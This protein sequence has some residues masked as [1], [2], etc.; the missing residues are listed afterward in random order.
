M[1]CDHEMPPQPMQSLRFGWDF[2]GPVNPTLSPILRPQNTLSGG[3]SRGACSHC[4]IVVIN[5]KKGLTGAHR[6]LL[7][8]HPT[9]EQRLSGLSQHPVKEVLLLPHFSHE[10]RWA[11]RSKRPPGEELGGG[12]TPPKPH[13]QCAGPP[14]V[15]SGPSCPLLR[16]LDSQDG[17]QR[18]QVPS[19]PPGWAGAMVT[20]GAGPSPLSR[21]H[22]G[23]R[24][25]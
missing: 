9:P 2:G 15:T 4:D 18:E 19:L 13:P 20:A 12:L 8:P 3:V 14:W 25:S 23:G 7:G 24:G 10:G 17:L 22:G 16:T 11:A 5:N 6:C 21:S 1:G